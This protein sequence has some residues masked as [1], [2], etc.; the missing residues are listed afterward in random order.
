MNC[1][2]CGHKQPDDLVVKE[3]ARIN[4]KKKSEAKAAASRENGKKSG[5]RPRKEKLK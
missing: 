2:K 1:E 5:G 3:A 4:G